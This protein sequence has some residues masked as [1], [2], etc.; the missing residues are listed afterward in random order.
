MMDNS[1]S[2]SEKLLK[3][4]LRTQYFAVLNSVAKGQPYSNLVAFATTKDLRFLIFVT[5]RN[6][7]KYRNMIEENRV[8]FL[9]DSRTN[10]PADIE[11]ATAITV[12]GDAHEE[13]ESNKG[14]HSLYLNKHPH[15]SH[16]INNPDNV[17]IVVT[18]AVFI[19]AGFDKTQ[20]IVI[21]ANHSF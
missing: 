7:L 5:G 2:M 14:F 20:R 17:L 11:K 4:I 6:T 8:S 10:H 12:I 21:D 18:V 15:L 9:I 19:I 16:F 1:H 13:T 3:E